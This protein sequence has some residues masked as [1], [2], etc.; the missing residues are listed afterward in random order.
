MCPLGRRQGGVW[1]PPHRPGAA[2]CARWASC[3]WEL[4]WRCPATQQWRSQAGGGLHLE[5]YGP[6]EHR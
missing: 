4:C 3:S 6:W 2:P 1:L 5:R